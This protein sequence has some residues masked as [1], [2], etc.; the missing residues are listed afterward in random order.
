MRQI[1]VAA[2]L[3]LVYLSSVQAE[4]GGSG[5]YAPGALGTIIDV[6]PTTPG[7]VGR[8]DYLHFD[9]DVAVTADLPIA[10]FVASGV[11]A[12]LDGVF[13]VGIYTFDQKI[14]DAFYS[15]GAVV[16]FLD[17]EVTASVTAGGVTAS[18]TDFD[19]GLG[20]I[21]LLPG[22]LAWKKG[23][24]SFG[25]LMQIYAPTGSFDAG[26]LANVG[27]N[28]WSFDP[29]LFVSYQGATNGLNAS[30]LGGITFNTENE[31]TNYQSGSMLHVEASAQQFLPLGPGFVGIGANAFVMRQISDDTGAGAVLG[32]FRGESW[33]IGPVVNY[34]FQ[35][36][37]ASGIV[38]FRWLPEIETKNRVR[39]DYF[40]LKTAI[41]F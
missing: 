7:F 15:V 11:E 14:F 26:Q 36:G 33:G 17:L 8:I 6:P 39:G 9:G 4:E 29:T 20:D 16:P 34:A 19:S 1:W 30:L 40:W 35:A 38:E 3:L 24:V 22:L 37:T 32:D 12:D 18:R 27:K 5:H 31:L 10:G 2:G 21:V 41:D 13:G 28:Y 23:D 25:G